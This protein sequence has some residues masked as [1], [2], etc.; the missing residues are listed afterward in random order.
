MALLEWKVVGRSLVNG[1]Q[2]GPKAGADVAS[3]ASWSTSGTA[4]NGYLCIHITVICEH[5]TMNHS[6]NVL[7]KVS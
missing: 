5:T 1:F 3:L 4:L 7:Y 6:S 2:L